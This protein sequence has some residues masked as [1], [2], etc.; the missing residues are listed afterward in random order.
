MVNGGVYIIM[1]AGGIG[2]GSDNHMTINNAKNTHR[3]IIVWI[4]VITYLKSRS[5][6]LRGGWSPHPKYTY[7]VTDGGGADG[8]VKLSSTDDF[9]NSSNGLIARDSSAK[10]KQGRF[11]DYYYFYCC[12]QV[13][14]YCRG[15]ACTWA[16]YTVSV[17]FTRK[18]YCS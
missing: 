12:P 13:R 17:V 18:S 14:E 8:R 3:N 6:L 2:N 11:V 10:T 9:H 16:C 7:Y 15:V 4:I 5:S 1:M